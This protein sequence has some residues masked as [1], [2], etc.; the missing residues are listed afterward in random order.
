MEPER[1]DK[2]VMVT[3]EDVAAAVRAVGVRPGDVAFFHSSL[4][5]MGTVVGGADAVIDG[6]LDA[7]GPEGT[8][9]VPTLCESH[10]AVFEEWDPARSPSYVGLITETLRRR[11]GA[12]RSDHATHSV[13]ALGARAAELTEGHG[14]AGRRPSPWGPAAFADESPWARLRRWNA[15]YLFIGV[16]FRVA[17]IVHYVE[18]LVAERALRRAPPARRDEFAA[19][20]KDFG[21]PGVWPSM[22][23]ADREKFEAWLADKGLVRYGRIGCATLRCVRAGALVD[24]WVRFLESDPAQWLP[25]EFVQWLSEIERIAT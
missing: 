22:R 12:F 25:K 14:R 23:V 3:R 17:T 4:S 24:E 2:R 19:R 21:K 7:A 8:V 1:G 6:F 9:A 18:A 20:L 13:A 16:T 5:S 11:P 15:A 10:E